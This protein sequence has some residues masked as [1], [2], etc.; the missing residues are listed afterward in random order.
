MILADLLDSLLRGAI[1]VALAVAL[2]GLTWALWVLRAW[3]HEAPRA[4]VD[5]ALLVA[6]VG[7]GSL[8]VVL[9]VALA[10]KAL[11]LSFLLER[12]VAGDLVTTPLFVA[13][14]ARALLAFVLALSL[15]WLARDPS[16]RRR[17]MLVLGL[18]ALV[19]AAGAW[20]THAAGR[21][22]GRPVLMT[23]TVVHGL[24]AAAWF[25][26]LVQLGFAW[27]L[28]GRAPEIDALWPTLVRRFSSLA[29]LCVCALLATA[30]ALSWAY[31]G[32]VGGLVGTAYG[33][34][35][36]TKIFLLTAALTLAALNRSAVRG[37]E[38]GRLR[39][40]LPYLAEAE[41]IVVLTILFAAS[42]LSAL[43]PPVD[44]P[45]A[46]RASV[47]EVVEVF[48]PKVPSLRTPSVETMRE[49]RAARSTGG[50]RSPEAYLWSNFSHNGAGLI[51][52]GMSAFALAGVAAGAGWRRHWPIG[53]LALAAFIYLRAAA[54]EGTW[55]FGHVGLADLD[56]EGIQHRIAAV[57]VIAL[58]LFEWWARSRAEAGRRRLAYVFPALAAAGALLLLT[59]SHTAFQAKSSFLVQV[60]HT[61]MGA[62]AAVMAAARWIE[63]RLG[64]PEGRLAG[65]VASVA[66]LLIALVL[67][68]YR[69]ANVV[70]PPN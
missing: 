48:R 36:L 64:S 6:R 16:A 19:A 52:L 68:F 5:R 60:T 8:G 24:V 49:A 23:L 50:V 28:A 65:A 30:G 32:S 47:G 63:L 7:A 3:R 31:A 2:G 4:A 14:A 42:A 12:S 57:L 41:V 35:I 1:H 43:P 44:L 29:L 39:S 18:A 56:T 53:F 9:T 26:G 27:R 55:P 69:E 13:G 58:G 25:G 17:W 61:T 66:L 11:I 51:L 33:S 10:L 62:L 34:L 70:V 40:R 59:H 22:E 67:V 21:L 54:N 15:G 46:D 20:S 45:H 37:D 38:P